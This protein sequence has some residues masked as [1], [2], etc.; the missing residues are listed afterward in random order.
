MK[1]G[2]K[3]QTLINLCGDGMEILD[4]GE[5]KAERLYMR[6]REVSGRSFIL[7]GSDG[8]EY[9]LNIHFVDMSP[10]AQAGDGFYLSNDM[11]RSMRTLH[12][13]TF[14]TK[15]GAVYARAPHDIEKNPEEFLI[16]EYS[17]GTTILLERWYG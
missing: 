7:D 15:I 6:I 4:Y 14:S 8:N 9:R 10:E 13:F 12:S 5:L 2:I 1:Y 3:Q 17:C 11:V 16:F